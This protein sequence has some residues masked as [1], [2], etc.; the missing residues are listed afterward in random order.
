MT[1]AS[2][3]RVDVVFTGRH[4]NGAI[5]RPSEHERFVPKMRA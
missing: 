5:G 2:S 4:I 1:E 3:A